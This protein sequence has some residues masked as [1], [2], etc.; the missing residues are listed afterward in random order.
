[1]LVSSI[2]EIVRM[3]ELVLV[4][5]LVDDE[6]WVATGVAGKKVG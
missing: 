4:D 1:M 3:V 6:T 5:E 2:S